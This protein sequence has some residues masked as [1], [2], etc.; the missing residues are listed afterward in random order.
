MKWELLNLFTFL[1]TG[2]IYNKTLSSIF[3]IRLIRLNTFSFI[4][5]Y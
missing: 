2:T 4:L 1:Y 5:I 3:S